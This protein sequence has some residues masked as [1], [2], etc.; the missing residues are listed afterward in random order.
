MEY[1][2]L[3]KDPHQLSNIAK[4]VD[5]RVLVPLHRRLETLVQCSGD[6]CRQDGDDSDDDISC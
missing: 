2:D 3:K 1:Y 6:T 5:P 4:K